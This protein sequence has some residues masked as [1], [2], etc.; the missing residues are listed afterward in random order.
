MVRVGLHAAAAGG[1]SHRH[2]NAQPGARPIVVVDADQQRLW[3]GALNPPVL[4]VDAP[5]LHGSDLRPGVHASAE[6]PA[7]SLEKAG[8]AD[9][10]SCSPLEPYLIECER[11]HV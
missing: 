11:L 1:P 5:N 9:L 7:V 3:W 4:D 6:G 8:D 2:N 10:G